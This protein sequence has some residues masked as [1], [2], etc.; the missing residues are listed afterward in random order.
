MDLRCK[1]TPILPIEPETLQIEQNSTLMIT[2][3]KDGAKFI[4]Q[5]KYFRQGLANVS[6]KNGTVIMVIKVESNSTVVE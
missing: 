4:L 3:Y 5:D 1:R 6:T 2:Q